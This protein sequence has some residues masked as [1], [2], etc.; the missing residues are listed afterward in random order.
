[1]H[2][3]RGQRGQAHRDIGTS[4]LPYPGG[5]V[6]CDTVFDEHICHWNVAFLCYQMEGGESTLERKRSHHLVFSKGSRATMEE[7]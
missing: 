5:G 2:G 6:H 1:M 3:G 7:H 4:W